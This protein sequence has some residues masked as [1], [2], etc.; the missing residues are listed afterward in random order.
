MQHTEPVFERPWEAPWSYLMSLLGR[1][2][3]LLGGLMFQNSHNQKYRNACF[4]NR[5]CSLAQLFRTTLGGHLGSCLIVLSP[6]MEAKIQQKCVQDVVRFLVTVQTICGAILG[7]ILEARIPKENG[8]KKEQQP[9]HLFL[10]SPAKPKK[11]TSPSLV[12]FIL[13]IVLEKRYTSVI[14]VH[15]HAQR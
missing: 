6:R 9:W 1:F 8:L 7:T 3:F 12:V 10:I 5:L 15:F 14:S 4:Q 13:I 2:G 11:K